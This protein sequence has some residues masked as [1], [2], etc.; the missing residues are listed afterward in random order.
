MSFWILIA[1]LKISAPF[2]NI[3]TCL[4]QD[5][6]E[7]LA[8]ALALAKHLN[9]LLMIEFPMSYGVAV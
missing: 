9:L 4:P 5:F 6:Q 1:I 3:F 8:T 2:C 7:G